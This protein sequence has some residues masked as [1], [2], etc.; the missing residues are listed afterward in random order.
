MSY[1]LLLTTVVHRRKIFVPAF[2][3]TCLSAFL[4]VPWLGQNFFPNS[5]NGE[6]ILHLRAKSGTRIEETAKLCDLVEDSIR[7]EIPQSEMNSV[8]DNIGLPVS[9]INIMHA[10]SGVIGAGD[11]D[12]LVSLKEEHHPTADYVRQLRQILPR[13]F[14]G[15]TFYFLPADMIT[16]SE[17][18]T[19][20]AHRHPT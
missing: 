5:D 18:R 7:R 13:D 2:L 19:A 20:R 12:V 3:L 15:T 4:L 14:P 10:T 8:L 1:Q 17:L 6:F 9:G 16:R 11:A